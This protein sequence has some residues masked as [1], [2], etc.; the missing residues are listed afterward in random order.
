MKKKLQLLF[1]FVIIF[2]M[3][4]CLPRVNEGLHGEK[5]P[6][7]RCNIVNLMYWIAED[8]NLSFESQLFIPD[9]KQSEDFDPYEWKNSMIADEIST[10]LM[11]L[12]LFSFI[13]RTPT[14]TEMRADYTLEGTITRFEV[15][16]IKRCMVEIECSIFDS[17]TGKKLAAIKHSKTGFGNDI[18]SENPSIDMTKSIARD[19]ALFMKRFDEYKKLYGETTKAY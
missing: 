18:G 3:S 9:F 6:F 14:S 13:D 15:N 8:A 10:D 17:H 2:L 12:K 19:I 4:S 16:F 11:E 5:L 7:I 1:V